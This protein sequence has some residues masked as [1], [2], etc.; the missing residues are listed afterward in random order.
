LKGIINSFSSIAERKNISLQLVSEV[1]SIQT[2]FDRD[3]FEKIFYNLLSNAFKFT[4]QGGSIE[5]EISRPDL[6]PGSNSI[7]RII[8]AIFLLKIQ[9][10]ASAKNICQIFSI[11]FI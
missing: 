4:P 11:N 7:Q 1:S 6:A 3:V 10:S 2:Y 5:V 9:V 8:I